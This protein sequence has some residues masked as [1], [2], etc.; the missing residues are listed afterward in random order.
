MNRRTR[1]SLAGIVVIVGVGLVLVWG[2]SHNWRPHRQ[3]N[4]TPIYAYGVVKAYPHDKTAFTQ[5]LA[6]EDGILYES[7]G[8][9]GRS[10]LR[11]VE[12]E[13]GRVLKIHYLP[14]EYFGEGL[15][16]CE[17]NIIQL[18]YRSHV[19]LVYD[20]NTFET[21][22][23]FRYSTE[24]WGIA[25]DGKHLIMSD[26]TSTL[27]MLD[28]GTFEEVGRIEVRDSEQPVGRLNELEYVNG[29]IYA[30]LF[31][32]SRIAMI[33]PQTGEVAGWIDLKGL[34]DRQALGDSADVLNG[35]A[36]DSEDDRLFV[37]GKRW[38]KLI[39]IELVSML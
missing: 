21:L 36:Y 1:L 4:A 23:E 29:L 11:K 3:W 32:T 8:L 30:N 27:H 28:P 26:G 34:S 33:I 15:T 14:G 25:Y 6:F 5:G 20:K 7:T 24:G 35:I 22:G 18:T 2:R 16:I 13:T 17:D 19:G 38:P 12:L 10:T 37:T 9:Q 39:E 31:P